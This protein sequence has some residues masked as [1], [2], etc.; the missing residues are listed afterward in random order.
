METDMN[1]I[2][3]LAL[4]VACVLGLSACGDVDTNKTTV[5]KK[6]TKVDSDG[7]Q[8]TKIETKTVESN[9]RTSNG[10]VI[11]DRVI[12]DKKDP[13]IKLGPLEVHKD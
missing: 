5:I 1:K 2:L 6:E 8:H 7:N 11:H 3:T 12:E 13:I 9:D 10:T 4:T